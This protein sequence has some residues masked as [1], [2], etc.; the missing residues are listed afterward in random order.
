[1]LPVCLGIDELLS[2]TFLT[3]KWSWLVQ[4]FL[5]LDLDII[6][7]VLGTEWARVSRVF[8]NGHS[9]EK[10]RY[11]IGKQPW[12]PLGYIGAGRSLSLLIP[13]CEKGKLEEAWK[14]AGDENLLPVCIYCWEKFDI[15]KHVTKECKYD[16]RMKYSRMLIL[17]FWSFARISNKF[18]E[19]LCDPWINMKLKVLYY[20][21]KKIKSR[22]KAKKKS[23]LN[24]M[25]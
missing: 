9:M 19:N 21:R 1:V 8:W 25:I 10:E 15:L 12:Q 11:T 17:I 18:L 13:E 16:S 23:I 20:E 4:I 6:V 14:T 2:F 24:F 7:A 22:T 3:S 5:G